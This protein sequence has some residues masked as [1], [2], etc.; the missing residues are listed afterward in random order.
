M[1]TLIKNIGCIATGMGSAALSGNNQGKISFTENAWILC[2]DEKI[3]DIGT[4]ACDKL[5]DNVVDAQGNLVTPGLVDSH[6]H[7]VFGGW[8]ENE[9]ALKLRGVEYLDILRRGGGI[10]STV[11]A[12]RTASEQEL[13]EK[14]LNSLEDMLMLGTTTCEAKSGYGLNLETELKQL[15][16]T[17]KLNDIQPVELVSTFMA[18][19]AVPKEYKDNKS[20]YIDEIINI[21]LP[22]V[23]QKK[24][25]EY[26]DVF[27]ETAVFNTDESRRILT[28]AQKLGLGAK[29]HADEIDAI[30][31]SELAGE[32]K[33]IS[34]EHLISCTDSGIKSMAKG[35]TIGVCLPCTS[36]YLG[37]NFAPA[38]KMIVEGVPVAIASDYNPGST[39]NF[40]L[41]LA[42]NIG[43]YKYRMTPEEVLNA[44]TIN[45]ASA[46][47]RAD[48]IGTVEV[49]KQAD[50]L[51]WNA[52]NLNRIFYRYGFNQVK[53][54]IKKGKII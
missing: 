36:F 48:M 23:A 17:K 18:A 47:G 13:I 24:L 51:I 42:M 11:E 21:M 44:V 35:G 34:S 32:I 2:E 39:P 26:C 38:R 37:K 53:T 30:G 12:T 9:L 50:L 8:R 15:N 27:C 6:T 1:K 14:T 49:G 52:T 46:I 5:T 25:A 19:H 28:A 10:L 43:C 29:I 40:N 3:I 31:G 20:A 4:G 45:A 54:V 7:L 16:V 33:A 22:V 41:Q